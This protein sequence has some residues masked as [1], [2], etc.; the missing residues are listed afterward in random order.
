MCSATTQP[1]SKYTFVHNL[2]WRPFVTALVGRNFILICPAEVN[3]QDLPLSCLSLLVLGIANIL[4]MAMHDVEKHE[5]TAYV[6]TVSASPSR[7]SDS[8]EINAGVQATRFSSTG[9]LARLRH[10]E[11]LLDK[12]LGVEGHGPDR[13]L[14][15]A[16]NPPNTWVMAALW[17]SGTMNLSCFATGFLGW[18]FGLSLSQS[19]LTMVFGTLLGAMV[20]GWCATM[21]IAI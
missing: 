17:A 2:S 10:Y 7:D 9:P 3:P 1:P 18:E 16:R 21:G 12:K 13:I 15:E 14:P 4:K 8:A 6:S 20:T 19:I 11:A 5:Q